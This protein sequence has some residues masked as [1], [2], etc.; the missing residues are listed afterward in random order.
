M[1]WPGRGRGHPKLRRDGPRD[2]PRG[3]GDSE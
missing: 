1:I 3:V 2:V